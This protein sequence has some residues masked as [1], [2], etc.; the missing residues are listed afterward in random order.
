[1]LLMLANINIAIFGKCAAIK[2]AG[3]PAV[4]SKPAQVFG[5]FAAF[6]D[7]NPKA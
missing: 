2:Q 6:I 7:I 1:M 4:L 3:N 5:G